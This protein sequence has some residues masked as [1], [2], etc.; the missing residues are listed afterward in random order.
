MLEPTVPLF[1]LEEN[2]AKTIIN[3][4]IS[5][6]LAKAKNGF[7]AGAENGGTK[8]RYQRR[9]APGDEPTWEK[10]WKGTRREALASLYVA[11]Y[12]R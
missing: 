12:L 8:T 4:F 11:N 1:F 7:V 6:H 3:R 9:N 10:K 5:T 2:Q